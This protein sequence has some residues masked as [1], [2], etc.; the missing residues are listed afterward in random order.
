MWPE[1]QPWGLLVGA[2]AVVLFCWMYLS[3]PPAQLAGSD[4]YYTYVYARSL[5]Y[6]GDFDFTNDYAIC[7][8][9]HG[10]NHDR[11]GGHPEN[12]FYVGPTIYWAPVLWAARHVIHLPASAPPAEI[13]ACRGPLAKWT[14]FLGPVLG[15]LTLLL[16]YR[17]ARR[18]ATDG[19][20]ALATALVGFGAP[21]VGYA[22]MWPHYAHVYDAFTCGLLLLASLRASESPRSW[23]RWIL[24]AILAGVAYLQ[25][26]PAAFFGIVAV[27]LAAV[28]LWKQWGR[29]AAVLAILAAGSFLTGLLPQALLYQYLYGKYLLGGS[30][31]GPYF[32]QLGH[33]HPWLSLFDPH[34]G[35]FYGSPTTWLAV[36]GIGPALRIKSAR[37]FVISGLLATCLVVYLSAAALDWDSS[38][39]FSNRRL[40]SLVA[41]LIPL[42]AAWIERVRH[43]L[44]AKR[45]RPFV[46]LGLAVAAPSTMLVVGDALSNGERV[47]TIE[48]GMSQEELYGGGVSTVWKIVDRNIG[49]LFVLPAEIVFALRYRLAMNSFRDVCEPW[50][51][52]EYRSVTERWNLPAMTDA[53]WARHVTGMHQ[54]TATLRMTAE[55]S[56]LVFA[57]QWP[58]ATKLDVTLRSRLPAR[59]TVARG[60]FLLR[61]QTYG[62]IELPGDDTPV[63][64]SLPIPEGS[65]DSGLLEI[66]L[67]SDAAPGAGVE[68]TAMKVVDTNTYPAR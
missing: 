56:T 20:A 34:G 27:T 33:A 50:V 52:Y 32:V 46:A 45:A 22:T 63:S 31:H 61:D 38:S 30:P 67:R 55:K 7:G 4:G 25:R 44:L 54:D 13:N 6:D 41:F 10:K 35:L 8:D 64:A 49:D 57:S 66:V 29:L 43:W 42:A 3:T 39:S 24:V 1:R 28:A 60:R 12:P 9:P 17:I 68:L 51:V 37:P 2:A 65:Y 62:T 48:R 26:P 18:L 23:T 14:L 5:V 11:G 59:V 47:T 40:T 53:R 19:P 58:F 15:G 21:I 36:L 16:G